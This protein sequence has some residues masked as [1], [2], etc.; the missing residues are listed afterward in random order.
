MISPAGNESDCMKTAKKLFY[1]F[2]PVLATG[3]LF[4]AEVVQL[5]SGPI[6]GLDTN[7]LRVFK[8][9]PYAAPP[10][11]T[12]RWKPPQAVTP[13]SAGLNCTNFG[14]SCPQ[15]P[16]GTPMGITSEDCLYLNVWTPATN[17]AAGLPVMVWIHGGGWT[18]GSGSMAEYDGA[19]LA[20]KG[21]VFVNFNYRLGPFGF[22]VHPLLSRESPRGVSGNYGLLDQIAALQWVQRNISAFG[23]DPGRVTIFGESAGSMSVARHLI[24]PLSTG[25]F[26]RAIS[27]SGGPC[28]EGYITPQS[29]GQMA[30]AIQ[31]GNN[32]AAALQCDTAP[33]VLQAL[34][35]KT[36]AE[37]LAVFDFTLAPFS[38]GMKFTPVIDGYVIPDDPAQLY[39]AGQSADVPVIIGSNGD[40]GNTFYD[41]MSVERYKYWI[42]LNFGRRA[43]EVFA[44][45]PAAGPENVRSAFDRLA[46]TAIFA[47]PARY[48]AGSWAA[49]QSKAYLYQF[50]RVSP[51]AARLN[52]GTFH[53]A[54]IPYVMGHIDTS[55]GAYAETDAALSSTM[56]D[57][58][59]N[60]AATGDPNGAGLPAWP[61]YDPSSMQNMEFGDTNRINN[62]L[63]EQ[64]CDLLSQFH[65]LNIS[66]PPPGGVFA[67]DGIY[68]DRV[69]VGWP[70]VYGAS[71]YELWRNTSPDTASAVNLATTTATLYDDTSV[72]AGIVY[73]YWARTLGATTN[74]GASPY[75]SGY[76]S[77]S[78][79]PAH[80]ARNDYDG[81]G[82][83]DL[84]LYNN[85]TNQ[86]LW[87]GLLS[88]CQYAQVTSAM[89]K[90]GDVSV[91]ADYD[92]D[93]IT[94]PAFYNSAA[95][96]WLLLKPGQGIL[97]YVFMLGGPGWE[98]SAADYDGDAKADPAVYRAATAEWQV[99]LSGSG[100]ATIH[101]ALGGPGW[102]IVSRDYDGDGRTDPAIYSEQS[103]L[104]SVLFSAGGYALVSFMFGGPGY[105]AIP[106]D[107]DGDMKSDP[108]I[109]QENSGLWAFKLSGIGYVEIVL[110]QPLGGTGYIP[111]PSDY[112][113]DGLAD[114]CV[115]NASAGEWRVL[116]SG[117]AYVLVGAVFGASGDSPTGP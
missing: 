48:V 72:Q 29:D 24:C 108:A 3:L 90:R 8:G 41:E 49:K 2:V 89:G 26:Q 53:S 65:Q 113:G 33:D 93:G 79:A 44:M 54:E 42:Q 14:P 75:D 104:W 71:A 63:L 100:Y 114:P 68:T 82:K 43:D 32:L 64:E 62:H 80:R 50:I 96:A 103:G 10:V 1:S 70:A 12:L 106:A 111:V 35:T 38:P 20:Q 13:W 19:V 102:K 101:L 25:L 21:V 36:S 87:K 58:W 59:V 116:F 92:G 74:S 99:N 73:Y 117:S 77:A 16:S 69:Q 61:G 51:Y 86:Y 40:E 110:T 95:A 45:F 6:S 91:P 78:G 105:A 4:A 94:E 23:G 47:E 9:I 7:G 55:Q 60:F 56:M 83:A 31:M 5:D 85:S 66:V 81:D 39:A 15:P 34:R 109:Y 46:S 112:D 98:A 27:E 30:K 115:F 11:G 88:A 17:S 18:W 76:C 84:S 37:I 107:Y 22:L 28:G 97:P 52:L 57:Y 67:T